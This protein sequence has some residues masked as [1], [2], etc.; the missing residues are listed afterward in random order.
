MCAFF[1]LL[2]IV[3][4]LKHKKLVKNLN[5]LV[6]NGTLVKNLEYKISKIYSRIDMTYVYYYVIEYKLPSGEVK[7]YRSYPTVRKKYLIEDGLCDL[8]I[9][10]NNPDNFYIGF[11]IEKE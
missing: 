10:Y 9:D 2:F 8:L 1:L 6:L 3:A 7:K 11:N 4:M 5:Y